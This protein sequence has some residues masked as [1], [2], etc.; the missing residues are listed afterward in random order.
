[1]CSP[2]Q[3][4]ALRA[5]LSDNPAVEGTREAARATQ[6]LV[7]ALRNYG[8]RVRDEASAKYVQT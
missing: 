4:E 1:M 5:L 2:L 7:T 6:L 8:C 3:L